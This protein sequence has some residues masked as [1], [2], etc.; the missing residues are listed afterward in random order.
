MSNSA[1]LASQGFSQTFIEQVVSA[2]TE[3]GNELASAIL[4]STPD[5]QRELQSL[6]SALEIESNQGMDALAESIYERQ[7]LATQALKDLYATTTM[8]QA[9][10]M[11]EQQAIL[12]SALVEANDKFLESVVEIKNALKEQLSEMEDG[13]GGMESTI[14]KFIGKL[15]DIIDKYKEVAQ[16]AKQ[17]SVPSPT[18]TPGPQG[19]IIDFMPVPQTSPAPVVST[20]P[21]TVVNV[22]VKTDPTESADMAGKAVAQV[23]QRYATR[24][25]AIKSL[26]VA[27]V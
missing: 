13:F 17:P 26:K 25:G 9:E 5:V 14:D 23:V 3:T 18:P 20:T 7:G 6:F 19:E 2:G 27:A 8:E 22:N 16:A 11:L 21:T 1:E 12:D 24:G 10:A 15:D 4:N